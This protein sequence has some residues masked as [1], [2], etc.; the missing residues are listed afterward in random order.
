[1]IIVERRTKLQGII[2]FI[3]L[4]FSGDIIFTKQER[5]ILKEDDFDDT[6]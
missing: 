5:R 1:M 3:G 6:S 4:I 2:E